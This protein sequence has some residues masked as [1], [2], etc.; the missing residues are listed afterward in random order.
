VCV[1]WV[2]LSHT[3][4][5]CVCVVCVDGQDVAE[6]GKRLESE[7]GQADVDHLKKICLC[8]VQWVYRSVADHVCVLP[9]YVCVFACVSGDLC[10]AL[11]RSACVLSCRPR[12]LCVWVS[13]S[14]RWSNLC[15]VVGLA[16][17]WMP[18]NPIS[19]VA[20]SLWT[21]RCAT[22]PAYPSPACMRHIPQQQPQQQ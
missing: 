18:L 14:R 9:M 11:Y 3:R 21:F 10:W 8:V 17:M 6:L 12:P 22:R 7:Q 13:E 20:L 4:V 16:T 15:G 1:G 2:S 5:C 19:V